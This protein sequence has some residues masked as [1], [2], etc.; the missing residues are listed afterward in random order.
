MPVPHVAFNRNLSFQGN[1]LI[2]TFKVVNLTDSILHFLHVMNPLMP[3]KE[4]TDIE[5][6]LF[7]DV[8]NE[9]NPSEINFSTPGDFNRQM[10]TVKQGDYMMVILKNTVKGRIKLGFSKGYRLIIE[11]DELMFPSL[12]IW[13]NNAGYPFGEGLE[14]TECAFEPIPGTCSNLERSFREGVSLYAAPYGTVSWKIIWR[15]ERKIIS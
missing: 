2:W 15:A 6:P 1:S 8:V 5:V 7:K 12:G 3:L 9:Y 13:W 4:I 11:Y 10:L 14:R